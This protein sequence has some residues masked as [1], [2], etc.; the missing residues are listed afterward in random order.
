MFLACIIFQVLFSLFVFWN[1]LMRKQRAEGEQLKESWADSVVNS[2]IS[3]RAKAIV[4][5]GLL[6]LWFAYEQISGDFVDI[7]VGASITAVVLGL[8]YAAFIIGRL[9]NLVATLLSGWA[10]SKYKWHYG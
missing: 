3:L 6:V 5:F 10:W 9:F 7:V 4:V 1:A 8:P 2:L